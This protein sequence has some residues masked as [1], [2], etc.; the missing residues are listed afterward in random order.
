MIYRGRF[1]RCGF[2]RY[3][4]SCSGSELGILAGFACF[5]GA[6]RCNLNFYV[7]GRFAGELGEDGEAVR[8][9]LRGHLPVHGGVVER[10]PGGLLGLEEAP[11]HAPLA[12]ADDVAGGLKLPYARR[13]G[14]HAVAHERGEAL[15]GE[16]P[17][18]VVLKRAYLAV[19]PLGLRREPVVEEDSVLDECE[20]PLAAVHHVAHYAP[21]CL[22]RRASACS[23]SSRARTMRLSISSLVALGLKKRAMLFLGILNCSTWLGF[24][25]SMMERTRAPVSEPSLE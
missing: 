15:D 19:D 13:H 21:P 23:S 11:V 5:V 22:P 1:P 20:R 8:L 25:S 4:F 2:S 16:H 3:G 24:Y 9:E 18:R 10:D 7:G 12:R 6:Q 17:L 14:V